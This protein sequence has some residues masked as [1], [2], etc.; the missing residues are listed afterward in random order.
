MDRYI[1]KRNSK[2]YGEIVSEKKWSIF[3]VTHVEQR[4]VTR[5][6]KLFLILLNKKSKILCSLSELHKNKIKY[7]EINFDTKT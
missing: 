4:N 1:N 3:L 7:H 6:I 2:F 5:L